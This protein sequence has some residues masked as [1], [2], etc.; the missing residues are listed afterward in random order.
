ML[1]VLQAKLK[2][3]GLKRMEKAEKAKK[4]YF[5]NVNHTPVSLPVSLAVPPLSFTS[6]FHRPDILMLE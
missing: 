1:P 2:T 4:P 5:S 6:V 3:R